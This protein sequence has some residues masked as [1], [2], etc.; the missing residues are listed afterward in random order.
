MTKKKAVVLEPKG[1]S[2]TFG[3]SRKTDLRINEKIVF[4]LL[5]IAVLFVGLWPASL[6]EIM[7]LS[8]QKLIGRIVYVFI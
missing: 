1:L 8:S 5:A 3:N 6:L 4:G 2:D 7:Q